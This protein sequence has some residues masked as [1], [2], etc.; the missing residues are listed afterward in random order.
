[1][2]LGELSE[3]SRSRTLAAGMATRDYARC[4]CAGA[5]FQSSVDWLLKCKLKVLNLNRKLNIITKHGH[6]IILVTSGYSMVYFYI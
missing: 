3:P 4:A 2:E 6:C 5:S 1:M